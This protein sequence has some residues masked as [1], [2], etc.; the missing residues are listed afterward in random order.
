MA[1]P[2]LRE[3]LMAAT[4]Q[5]P[6]AAEPVEAPEAE[7][8]APEMPEEHAPEGPEDDAQDD[9]SERQQRARDES[10][11]FVRGQPAPKGAAGVLAQGGKP[12]AAAQPGPQAST[13]TANEPK[14]PASWKPAVREHW[15]KLPPEVRAEVSRREKE[16]ALAVQQGAEH[17]KVAEAFQSTIQP[18]RAFIQGEPTQ[19]VGN[20]LQTAVVL[21]TGTPQQKAAIAAQIVKG[22]GV[23]IEHLA[24]ALDGQAPPQQ[25]QQAQQFRDPRFDQFLGQLQQVQQQRSQQTRAEAARHLEEFATKAE[26]LDDVGPAMADLMAMAR[27]RGQPMSMED[28]YEVACLASP[29]VRPLYQQRKAAQE[30]ANARASTQRAR[31]AASSVRH[32]PTAPASSAQPASLRDSIL[33][34][35]KSSGRT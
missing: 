35:W 6:A 5:A 19:V 30:A 8:A 27:Q 24:A 33:A 10:G 26:F 1:E 13:Q 31:A 4:Q 7:E 28:A 9:G 14:A 20:L 17:R 12:M 32:E 15:G 2:T 11:R 29:D 18:Y 3:S 25:A 21:Q 34:A 16:A 23:D 22:Y